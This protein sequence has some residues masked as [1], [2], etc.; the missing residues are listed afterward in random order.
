[1]NIDEM[2]IE[3]IEK[4]IS[5]IEE[6]KNSPEADCTAL[7]EE[8]RSLKEQKKK[9]LDAAEQRAKEL[10]DIAT[11]ET[12]T[13]LIQKV[14][15]EKRDMGE[16]EKEVRN[17][18]AYIEA[19]ANYIKTKDDSECRSLVTVN[20][21]GTV[22]VPDLVDEIVKTAW[23]R[24]EITR[25]VKKTYLKGNLEVGFEVS[26]TDAGVHAEGAAD[27]SEET[28]VLNTTKLVPETI[29]K[30]IT[31]SKEAMK[32]TGEAFLRYIYDELTYKIAC[33]TAERLIADIMACGTV[34]T[35]S[36]HTHVCAVPEITESTIALG[37]VANAISQLSDDAN[38]VTLAMNKLT[39][40]AFK[41]VQYAGNYAVDPF[42]GRRVVFNNKIPAYSVATTGDTYMIVG[43]FGYGAQIN[44]PEGDDI[45]FTFDNVSQAEKGLVKIVGE[46]FLGHDVVAPKAFCKVKK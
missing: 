26:A 21:S 3:D 38:D 42:E 37:T 39:Y 35:T 7:T 45:E 11:G 40:G 33:K 43:D 10:N 8:V 5:E 1:M 46:Q 18:A 24:N 6:E 2:R 34:S 36:G 20:G 15:E 14:E 25:L 17:S 4:R 13:E 32:L 19:Y 31:V 22:P 9:L 29:M 44:A 41:A 12:R 16:K 27:V 23:E 28:L 30:W